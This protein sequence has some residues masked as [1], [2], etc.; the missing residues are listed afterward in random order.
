[1]EPVQPPALQRRTAQHSWVGAVPVTYQAGI[2]L[3]A[4]IP[5]LPVDVLP[6]ASTLV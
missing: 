6:F 1:M 4:Q 3:A 5:Q 2:E